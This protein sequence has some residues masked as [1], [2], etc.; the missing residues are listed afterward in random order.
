MIGKLEVRIVRSYSA[1][2]TLADSFPVPHKS[3]GDVS[4]EDGPLA[5]KTDI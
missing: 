3:F 5:L 4:E 1:M 2:D